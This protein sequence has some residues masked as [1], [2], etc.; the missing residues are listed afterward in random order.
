[1]GAFTARL[2][3]G[4]LPAEGFGPREQ[5]AYS[6]P[7]GFAAAMALI[8]MQVDKFL[9][10]R[11]YDDSQFAV[12][13]RG[14]FQ[15]PVVT[16]LPYALADV[17]VPRMVH[18]YEAG[19]REGLLHLWR[20]AARRMWL[21]M[22]PIFCYFV[23]VADPFMTLL[24]TEEYRGTVPVFRIFLL[25]LPVRVAVCAALLR[26]IGRT[27]TVYHASLLLLGLSFG[28]SVALHRLIGFYG[29]P[30]A[31]VAAQTLATLFML[32]CICRALKCRVADVM[33]WWSMTGAAAAAVACGALSGLLVWIVSS[34]L[35]VPVFYN[36]VAALTG[37]GIVFGGSYLLGCWLLGLLT[38]DD[39][40][41]ARDW[42]GRLRDGWSFLRRRRSGG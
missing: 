17:L 38:P 16:I 22:M 13:S 37:A 14:A 33:P 9:I 10:A 25:L 29:P 15:L 35:P 31:N 42:L 23:A 24:W 34:R 6:L 41:L 21:V 36:R 39:K 5:W 32:G 20:E 4:E 8:G 3:G 26:A 28:A 30:V 1:L 18:L 11:W 7:L 2:P 19:D 40:A 12:Y 27:R